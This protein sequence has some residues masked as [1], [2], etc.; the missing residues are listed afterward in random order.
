MQAKTWH[1]HRE[2]ARQ[3]DGEEMLVL[4]SVMF[5][6]T[7]RCGD[8]QLQDKAMS[9]RTDSY[10]AY[11]TVGSGGERAKTSFFMGETTIGY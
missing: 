1:L 8:V 11:N 6:P 7:D 9:I 2:V 4:H 5:V 10:N 3:V